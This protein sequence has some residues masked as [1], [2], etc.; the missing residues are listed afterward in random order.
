MVVTRM[1][2]VQYSKGRAKQKHLD[3]VSDL[4]SEVFDVENHFFDVE[5]YVQMF[6]FARTLL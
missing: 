4:E 1:H 5:N 6:C 2:N 3:V